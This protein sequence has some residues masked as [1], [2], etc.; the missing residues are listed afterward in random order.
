MLPTD[1]DLVA[2]DVLP[3]ESNAPGESANYGSRDLLLEA[4]ID[5]R[6]RRPYP[7]GASLVRVDLPFNCLLEVL[8]WKEY[9]RFHAWENNNNLDEVCRS[10]G[11]DQSKLQWYNIN[12][13]PLKEL[14]ENSDKA[15]YCL[16]Y[17]NGEVCTIIILCFLRNEER[18][19]KSI[20][21][22]R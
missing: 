18:R 13:L 21:K 9:W 20:F 8:L 17:L 3:V 19:R 15:L 1:K 4:R 16:I 12:D 14:A 7:L 6:R 2:E 5:A 11:T 22:Y 10:W